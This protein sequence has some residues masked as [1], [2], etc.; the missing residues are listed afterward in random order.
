MTALNDLLLAVRQMYAAIDRFDALAAGQLGVDRTALRAINAMER[1]SASPGSLG[2]ALG[3]SSGSVT[4]LLDRLQHAGH[5]ERHL[6]REDGRR[7]DA[8]L[9]PGTR[10]Q[11]HGIYQNLG[12]AIAQ[13]FIGQDEADVRALATGLQAL[14]VAF[15]RAGPMQPERPALSAAGTPPSRPRPDQP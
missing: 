9:T 1:G 12:D 6:S 3:L 4:A 7:R 15:E 13:A 5:I 2:M 8:T 10:A 11:A 14:A